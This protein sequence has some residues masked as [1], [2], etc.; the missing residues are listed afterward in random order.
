ML[1]SLS[2]DREAWEG[3]K[4][5]AGTVGRAIPSP[6]QRAKQPDPHPTSC[7]SLGR[8]RDLFSGTEGPDSPLYPKWTPTAS[9]RADECL[10]SQ[11]GGSS[12]VGQIILPDQPSGRWTHGKHPSRGERL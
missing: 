11:I 2:L 3:P 1:P 9:L 8:A 12:P 5:P 6:V 10:A 7:S 4:V